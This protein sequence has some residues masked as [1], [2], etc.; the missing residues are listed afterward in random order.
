MSVVCSSLWLENLV[1][2]GVVSERHLKEFFL[3]VVTFQTFFAWHVQ[4]SCDWELCLL[5]Q[6]LILR[7]TCLCK[8]FFLGTSEIVANIFCCVGHLS[9]NKHLR[10]GTDV[11]H[12]LKTQEL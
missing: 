5:L 2:L 7:H 6:V 8:E 9:S 12:K 11:S 10:T 3:T 1:F 4:L